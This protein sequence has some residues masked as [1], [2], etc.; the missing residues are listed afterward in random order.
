MVSESNWEKS[1][2][3]E[4]GGCSPGVAKMI[5]ALLALCGIGSCATGYA[6]ACGVES[7]TGASTDGIT[8]LTFIAI[9]FMLTS[10]MIAL[11]YMHSK[12]RMDAKTEMWAKDE[13]QNLLISVLLFAGLLVFFSGAC[14]I[15][16]EYTD[17][18]SPIAYSKAYLNSLLQ[19]N[20]LS[21]VRTLTY[22]SI[23]E[24][25]DATK[26]IFIGAMPF[27]GMGVGKDA[28][29]RALSAHKELVMDIYLP[30]V[31]SLTAQKYLLDAIQ[32]VGA[33]VLLPFGFVMRLVPFTR[34]FGNIMI[35]IF[36]AMYIVVPV[37]YA[38]SGQAFMK[39]T[40]SGQA[41]DSRAF[42]SYGLDAGADRA[43][44]SAQDTVLFRVG[45]TI[46]QAVF[47]PNLVLVIAITCA[48]SIS[49]ALHALA[50]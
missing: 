41:Y 22:D 8:A 23:G 49:K 42:Y 44:I 36:F 46:P 29:L 39:I 7:F 18:M 2:Q 37:A 13:A 25:K 14:A 32:W 26:Y 9:A 38:M 12:M 10:F 4:R 5:V 27:W 21:I 3:C 16:M 6:A 45:S 15:A 17:G 35:A 30:I 33:S 43:K 31:A 28:N 40:G 50:M 11:A 47:V 20:G 1:A 34:E 19:N 24:Q 48:M